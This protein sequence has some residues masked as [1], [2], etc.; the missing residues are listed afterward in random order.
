MRRALLI[1]LL[2]TVSA[3]F[4][5][6]QT[7]QGAVILMGE[8]GAEADLV[9]DL[10]EVLVTALL[11]KSNNRYRF[12]GKEG[13]V[14]ELM[15]RRT[16]SGQ[17][18]IESNDCIRAYA[19][20]RGLVLMVYGKVG[21]AAYGYWLIITKIGLTGIPDEIK[22]MKVE[23]GV[24]KLIED[25]EAAADWLLG[26]DKTWLQVSVDQAGALLFLDDK[27]IGTVSDAP[28]QVAPGRHTVR[29]TKEGYEAYL[30]DVDCEQG[31][32]CKVEATMA[33]AAP[34]VPDPIPP[35]TK[36]SKR[37][38]TKTWKALGWVFTGITAAGLGSAV[39]FTVMLNKDAQNYDDR[40]LALCPKKICEMNPAKFDELFTDTP[41]VKQIKS[42]GRRH[43]KWANVSWIGTGV[44]GAAALSFF[45]VDA[46]T[47]S[48]VGE[49]SAFRRLQP[50]VHPGFTGMTFNLDF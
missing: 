36:P 2:L 12:L 6:G 10:G 33:V 35:I 34:D 7:G 47:P 17:V 29:L 31:T 39:Y 32:L 19:Q 8:S 22:K 38:K 41:E 26:P 45:L 40:L 43:A 27:E 9:A 20:E 3:P 4:A 15:K 23:G 13:V 50:V 48:P 1:G 5:A 42:D 49:A 46:F 28:L 37:K 16:E 14:A 25:V 11:Q 24:T 21:K 44:A 30:G 18:C